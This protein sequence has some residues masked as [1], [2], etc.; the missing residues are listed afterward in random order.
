MERTGIKETRNVAPRSLVTAI[1]KNDLVFLRNFYLSNFESFRK[2]A[3]RHNGT[4]ELAVLM[5]QEAFLA[6]VRD[7][8]TDFFITEDIHKLG[9]FLL[10]IAKNKFMGYRRKARYKNTIFINREVDIEEKTEA[11]EIFCEKLE[12]ITKAMDGLEE[13][14][15]KMLGLYYFERKSFKEVGELMKVSEVLIHAEKYRCQESFFKILPFLLETPSQHDQQLIDDFLLGRSGAK[16]IMELERKIIFSPAYG[17]RLEEQRVLILGI[18]EFHLKKKLKK[19]HKEVVLLPIK[20]FYKTAWIALILSVVLLLSVIIWSIFYDSPSAEKLFRSSFVVRPGLQIPSQQVDDLDVFYKGMK[21]YNEGRF[22]RAIFM[23][24]PLYA[25]Q[26]NN[27]TV[28]LYL[29]VANL[30]ADNARQASKYLLL[31]QEYSNSPF[32]A[33]FQYYYALSLI[34]QNRI[35]EAKQLLEHRSCEKCEN[36][37]NKLRG[38]K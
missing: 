34:K 31:A 37:L 17:E 32:Y 28:L 4:D 8:K 30:A 29:G 23:W 19:F 7:V 15:Q 6:M 26:P 18:E 9:Q 5:Y 20:R 11:E 35:K 13:R 38:M 25:A 2:Y 10:H 14:C 12:L 1:K 24:E 21:N 16:E 36:L 27:D 33:D 3:I 22:S